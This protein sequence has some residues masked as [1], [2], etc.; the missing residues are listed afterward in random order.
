MT[1]GAI[2]IGILICFVADEFLQWSP[3]VAKWLVRK[4]ARRLPTEELQERYKEEWLAHINDIPG[5]LSKLFFAAGIIRAAFVVKGM[6]KEHGK[7]PSFLSRF[8]NQL[9]FLLILPYVITG[10]FLDASPKF[11]LF[12]ATCYIGFFIAAIVTEANFF[13]I[14]VLFSFCLISLFFLVGKGL[15]LIISNIKIEKK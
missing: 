14:L 1:V 3:I 2:I 6:S 9:L 7:T 4:N 11:V 8:G 15:D 12:A 10:M 5:R 13:S